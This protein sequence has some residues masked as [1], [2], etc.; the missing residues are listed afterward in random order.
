MARQK[1]ASTNILAKAQQ[2]LLGMKAVNA[3]LNLG[4]GL[5]TTSFEKEI[6][7]MQQKLAT[8]HG[9]L[10][11]ADEISDELKMMDKKIS[12]LSG[13]VLSGVAAQYGRDSIEYE[14]AGG[15]R[16]SE[17]RRRKR[18]VEKEALAAV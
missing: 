6:V 7:T 18:P 13:R 14:K 9:L 4:N 5:T 8:Y 10:A 3:K 11:Q 15:I 2:R 1:K 16:S 12:E 17:R